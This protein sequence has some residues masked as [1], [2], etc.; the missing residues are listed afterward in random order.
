MTVDDT[1]ARHQ[2]KNGYTTHIGNEQFAWFQSTP[3]KSR[4]NF[5]QLLQAGHAD[6][7]MDAEALAYLRAQKLP[8]ALVETLAKPP[9]DYFTEPPAWHAHLTGVGITKARH[10]RMATEGA[11]LAGALSHRFLRDLAIVSDDAGQF[12]ILCHGWCGV[13]AERTIHKLRP[14]NETPRA[15]LATVRRQIWDY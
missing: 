3:T 2:G 14:L 6:Y 4:S 7:R 11:L 8:S 1:G 15:E 13:H 12:N 9:I 10:V 5:L